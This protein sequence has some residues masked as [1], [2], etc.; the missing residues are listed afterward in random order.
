MIPLPQSPPFPIRT[1]CPPGACIC[2]RDL[3]LK[4]PQ[5][6]T[7]ILRLT[8]D[9]EKKLV[10]R[11][12]RISSYDE[13]QHVAERMQT[14]LG[15]ILHISPSRREVRTVRGFSIQLEERPGLCR[16]TRQSI[17]AAIRRCLDRNPDIAFAIL[18]ARD[19][20]G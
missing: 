13:L 17:P 2:N 15:I 19:L 5:A 3:L 4:D 16:N 1:E 8:R 10:A 14:Q 18:N 7:R 12:D 9:E 6:D 11:I 20:L